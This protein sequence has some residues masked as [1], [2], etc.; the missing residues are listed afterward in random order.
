MIGLGI[1]ALAL[2]LVVASASA[3]VTKDII[4]DKPAVAQVE[5][6]AGK[7][8]KK[9]QITW[10]EP[11]QAAP[12]ATNCNDGN[13]AGYVLGGAAGGIAGSQV[14]KGNGKTAATIGGTLGG[15]YLGG[16]YIP[17]QNVT[18]PR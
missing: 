2:V 15:A 5:P 7:T 4:Q 13:V 1:G 12:A 8:V 11:R 16:Q 17:L 10:N 9:E 3:L 18:C 14:G 6:A